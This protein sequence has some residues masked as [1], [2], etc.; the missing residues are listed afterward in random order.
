MVYLISV[1]FSNRT[2][3]PIQNM[4]YKDHHFPNNIPTS[5]PGSEDV[6]MYLQSYADR[7]NLKKHIKFNHLVIRVHPIENGKWEVIVKDQANNKI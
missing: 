1:I 5:Y 4:K 6:L 2:N 3:A 7:F